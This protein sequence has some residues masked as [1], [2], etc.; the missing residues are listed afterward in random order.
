ML[1]KTGP[2]AIM[3]AKS[4]TE[5]ER[6]VVMSAA[7]LG[8]RLSRELM[9][10][11]ALVFGLLAS[12]TAAAEDI[13]LGLLFGRTGPVANYVPP[14]LDAVALAVDEVN[15]NGGILDGQKLQ[16][17]LGDT[18][19]T[20][21]GSVEAATKLVSDDKVAAVIGAL[22]SLTTVAAAGVTVPHGVLLI[23]P[24]ATAPII[25]TMEDNDLVFRVVPSDADQ[26]WVLAGLAYKQGFKRVALTYVDNEYGIGINDTFRNNFENYRGSVTV[27]LAHEANKTSY[28]TELKQLAQFDPEALVLADFATS[29]GIT[30]VKEAVDN[31]LFKQFIGTDSLMDPALIEAIGADNLKGIFFTA[32]TIDQS[33]SAAQA[34]ETRYSAAYETTQGK[35]Y[36]AHA[37][38]AVMLAALAIE[39]AGTTN[40]VAIRDAL[41]EICCAPGEAIEPGDW[42][43]AKA[44]IAAGNDIDYRGASGECDFDEYGNVRGIYGHYI[45]ENGSFKQI[46]LLKP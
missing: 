4:D 46:E 25:T 36:I 44:A 41:R 35:L 40:P 22:T 32:P 42:A 20:A 1:M 11:N 34:F 14:I 9:C 39:K 8:L 13:R 37:Y 26:G 17:I 45:V 27:A 12:T 21:N 15:N 24:S 18:K 29:G 3:G 19:D 28:L 23:S 2:V 16:T 5:S 10:L 33:T 7:I 6:G 30:I 38:D 43:K 31:R